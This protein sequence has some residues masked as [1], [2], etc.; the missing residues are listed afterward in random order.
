MRTDLA[1]LAHL[2]VEGDANRVVAAAL[3]AIELGGSVGPST[4][5]AVKPNFTYP[6]FKPG[7]TTSPRVLT[8]LVA[9]LSDYTKHIRIVESDGGAHAWKAEDAFDGHGVPEICRLYGARAVNLS[10]Q[11]RTRVATTIARKEVAV[12]LPRFLLEEVD[13][14]ITVPV[15]KVHVMTQVSLGFKNQWGCL[16]DVKRLREHPHFAEKVIAI[17]KLLRTRLGVFDGTYFLDRSGPMDGEAV[18]RDLLIAGEV[19][20]ATRVCCELM[21]VDPAKVAHLRLATTEGLMPHHV[22]ANQVNLPLESLRRQCRLQR[23]LL[24]WVTL[25][26]FHSSLATKLIYDS[27]FAAPIHDLLYLIRGR[28]RDIRPMW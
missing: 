1:Y 6:V 13:F 3:A 28:P 26:V 11:E 23:S 24:N 7:V 22:S 25:G 8:A 2:P 27:K 9:A 20:L 21:G 10:T 12:E 14:F 15:P 17:N 18:R 19:G 5:V 4:R 16:P